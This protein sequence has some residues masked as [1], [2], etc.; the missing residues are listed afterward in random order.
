MSQ[1]KISKLT[2]LYWFL[3]SDFTKFIINYDRSEI[4]YK[5]LDRNDE[6][7]AVI[8]IDE[9][10]NFLIDATKNWSVLFFEWD[11]LFVFLLI[12]KKV[13]L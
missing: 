12:F 5:M 2:S 13:I 7:S 6:T 8:L 9:I 1:L 4:H 11:N 10:S 3:L